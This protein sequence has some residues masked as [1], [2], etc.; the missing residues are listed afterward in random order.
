MATGFYL[1]IDVGSVST[2]LVVIDAKGS[3]VKKIYLR[4]EG[5]PI[6]SVQRG[7]NSTRGGF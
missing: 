6:A 4:T 7:L 2:N 3:I 1:G 5:K